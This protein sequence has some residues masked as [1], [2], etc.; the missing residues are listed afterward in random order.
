M[1]KSINEQSFDSSFLRGNQSILTSDPGAIEE[2]RSLARLMEYLNN[3]G[4]GVYMIF[5]GLFLI[6]IHLV[7]LINSWKKRNAQYL[8]KWINAVSEIE[9]V[10][11]IAGFAYANK[12]YSFPDIHDQ[13][14]LAGQDIA[15]PLIPTDKRIANDFELSHKKSIAVIT[16]SNMSGKSTFLRTIGVNIV[17]A[18]AGA[19][20]CASKMDI[21]GV[22]SLYQHE[23]F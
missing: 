12:N 19:P 2:I 4:N 15:H 21:P 7:R 9:A 6:D 22:L 3:R 8:N 5:N 23:N 16:G 14:I 20:V 17:L 10:N 11:G 1:I 18:F 13:L